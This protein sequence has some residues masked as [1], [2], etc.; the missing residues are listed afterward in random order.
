M[1]PSKRLKE[2]TNHQLFPAR[3]KSVQAALNDP[4][5]SEERFATSKVIALIDV[6][7]REGDT[8]SGSVT[9]HTFPSQKKLVNRV[10]KGK[11]P[12][13]PDVT[14]WCSDNDLVA[15][16]TREVCCSRPRVCLYL[17]PRRQT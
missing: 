11:A 17:L 1:N 10:A 16:A 7:L 9:N 5:L 15:L 6:L 4:N 2:Q 13:K 14:I 3:L 8:T 12:F